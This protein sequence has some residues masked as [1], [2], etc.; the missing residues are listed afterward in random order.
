MNKVKCGRCNTVLES[1][2][3]HDFQQCEC[4]NETFTDGGE[5]YQRYG[6]RDLLCI[7]VLND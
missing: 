3:V 6:G 4:P 2:S 7:E 5:E 1:K